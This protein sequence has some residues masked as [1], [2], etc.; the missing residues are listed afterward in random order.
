MSNIGLGG[1]CVESKKE[2]LLMILAEKEGIQALKQVFLENQSLRVAYQDTSGDST[3][4]AFNKKLNRAGLTKKLSFGA[5]TKKAPAK[6]TARASFFG[7]LGKQIEQLSVA[8][9]DVSDALGDNIEDDHKVNGEMGSGDGQDNSLQAQ[10]RLTQIKSDNAWISSSNNSSS[11]N[12]DHELNPK[13]RLSKIMS[14]PQNRICADCSAHKPTWGST[15]LGVF[16]CTQCAGV[17]RSLGVHISAM[18]STKLDD[19]NH[20]QLDSMDA[21]GNIRANEKFEFHVPDDFPKPHAQEDRYYREQYIRK[22]YE[23]AAFVP[24][25]R[26]PP[27]QNPTPFPPPAPSLKDALKKD[28]NKNIG[29]VEFIGYVNVKL[30][31]GEN[32]LRMGF[33]GVDEQTNPYAVLQLGGQKVSSKVCSNTCNPLWDENVMLCWDGVEELHVDIFSSDEHM[34]GATMSLLY[35]LEEE[36]GDRKL[37]MGSSRGDD[38]VISA[39]PDL[40]KIEEDDEDEDGDDDGDSDKKRKETD[41][42]LLG[43]QFADG[44]AKNDDS[45]W[46]PLENRDVTK[47][48]KK[49][50]GV[51]TKGKRVARGSVFK[52]RQATGGICLQ[53]KFERL[54]H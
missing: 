26:K 7:G 25:A 51:K 28:S 44:E 30:L 24:L 14:R 5:G 15:N 45:M 1:G 9:R 40:S 54:S 35:L 39:V 50:M 31:R 2:M 4:G 3:K 36:E 23:Q 19:W 33:K 17:H 34:G 10:K 49:T 12:P 41:S 46:L 42:V 37:S 27:M 52:P 20:N 16:L 22:K 6:S 13:E 43:N 47:V 48:G 18:L 29:M 53:I 11:V 38:S 8:E 21:I 32:L